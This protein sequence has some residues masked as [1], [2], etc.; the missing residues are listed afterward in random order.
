MV[1]SK[2]MRADAVGGLVELGAWQ[3]DGQ[4]TAAC[5]IHPDI[6]MRRVKGQDHRRWTFVTF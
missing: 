5:C 2:W 3:L 4:F 6:F 1:D